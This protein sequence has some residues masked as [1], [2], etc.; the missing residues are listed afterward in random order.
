MNINVG[1][2]SSNIADFINIDINPATGCDLV[3][4]VPPLPLMDECVDHILASHFIEH[5]PTD[6]KIELFN[7]FWRVLKP[8]GLLEIYVPYF[9]KW[10]AIADPTHISYWVPESGQYFTEAMAYLN[11]GIKVWSSSEWTLDDWVISARM[12]K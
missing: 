7:E 9:Y 1:S 4:S 12:I 3:A 2:G 5:V 10:P 11:Y 6:K 8:G